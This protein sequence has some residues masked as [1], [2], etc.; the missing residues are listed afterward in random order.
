MESGQTPDQSQVRMASSAATDSLATFE[1]AMN[2][3]V[4]RMELTGGQIQRLMEIKDRAEVMLDRAVG[5]SRDAVAE[6]KR[7]PKSFLALGLV[8]GFLVWNHVQAR[9]QQISG[10]E[11]H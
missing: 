4:E 6:V 11:L 7:S 8:V 3:L 10:E 5:F 9:P 2:R 1:Q